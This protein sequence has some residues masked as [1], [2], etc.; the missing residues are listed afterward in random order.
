[1]NMNRDLLVLIGSVTVMFAAVLVILSN[2]ITSAD[3]NFAA[4]V[5]AVKEI[6]GLQE[7]I[8]AESDV[9]GQA[10]VKYLEAD[11]EDTDEELDDLRNITLAL[12]DRLNITL[13]NE[14]IEDHIRFDNGVITFDN[15]TEVGI[16]NIFAKEQTEVSSNPEPLPGLMEQLR[17]LNNKVNE[18]FMSKNA[19]EPATH[20][21]NATQ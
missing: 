4:I 18:L 16:G 10:F 8:T 5:S 17:N 15:G 20:I 21:Y 13:P 12:A 19:T 11:S 1:M 7:N 9:R 14:T 6:R 3:R 2:N